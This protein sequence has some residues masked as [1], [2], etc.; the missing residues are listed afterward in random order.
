MTKRSSQHVKAQNE[1][2]EVDDYVCFFCNKR[3]KSNHGH[4][5]VLYSENGEASV[6]NMITL[7]PKC[8]RGYHSGK[9]KLDIGRF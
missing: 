1:A 5:I 3:N 4:H 2:K 8:H 7:C 9:I 6:E